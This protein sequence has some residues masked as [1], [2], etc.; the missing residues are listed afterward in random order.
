M[1]KIKTVIIDD[2]PRSLNRLKILFE[3]FKEVE[4]LEVFEDSEEGL[5]YIL[6]KEPDLVMLDVEMPKLSGLEIA[7]EVGKRI[8]NTKIIF[9]SAYSHYAIKAIKASVFDYLLKP[10]SIDELKESLQRFKTKYKINLNER[11]IEIIREMSN[12]LSSK[13]IGDKLFISKHTVDT[14]RRAILEKT[15]C[16]NTAEL[17][18]YAVKN[19]LI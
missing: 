14:Y 3:N 10:V 16:Q 2:E 6:E 17:I 13:S 8:A 9:F 15:E 5:K 12:G 7:D 1:D 19:G 18:K 4:V 11:E